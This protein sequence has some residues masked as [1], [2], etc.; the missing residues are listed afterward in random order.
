M[1]IIL[2]KKFKKLNVKKK[3]LKELVGRFYLIQEDTQNKLPFE[4]EEN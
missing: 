1:H 2:K 3:F 4:Y